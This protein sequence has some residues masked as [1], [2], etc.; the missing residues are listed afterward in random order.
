MAAADPAAET[1]TNWI[2]DSLPVSVLPKKK[3]MKGRE[4]YQMLEKVYRPL[5]F[6]SYNGPAINFQTLNKLD[7][8]EICWLSI[9]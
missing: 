7:S 3:K 8:D 1:S 4:E 5:S 2:V 9:K 6:K